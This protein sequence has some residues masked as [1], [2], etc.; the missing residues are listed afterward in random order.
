M[1]KISIIMPSYNVAPY[2]RECMDSVLVQTLSDIEVIAVDA[3]STDGTREILEE[4]A[5]KDSRVIIILKC[6]FLLP[7]SHS[8]RG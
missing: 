7:G 2:I 5:R 6:W 1:P 4:Y 3:D 8:G